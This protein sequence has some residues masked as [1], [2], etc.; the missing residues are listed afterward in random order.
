MD[1]GTAFTMRRVAMLG[2]GAKG[3]RED[4]L[5]G[6]C[7]TGFQ[8]GRGTEHP[9]EV[10]F[11]DVGA[12]ELFVAGIAEQATLAVDFVTVDESTV[13]LVGFTNDER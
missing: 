2:A 12:C 13:Q 6:S 7:A 3:L 8:L 1:P 11:A 4:P 9:F 10:R 5:S